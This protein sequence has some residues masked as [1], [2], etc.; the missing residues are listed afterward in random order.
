MEASCPRPMRAPGNLSRAEVGAPGPVDR[1]IYPASPGLSFSSKVNPG[2]SPSASAILQRNAFL[3]RNA[4]AL[5]GHC[6]TFIRNDPTENLV[7]IQRKVM[8]PHSAAAST[9]R[10]P[11]RSLAP[12]I[13]PFTGKYSSPD[14]RQRQFRK[15]K[16]EMS[17]TFTEAP[18]EDPSGQAKIMY[19]VP[20]NGKPAAAWFD[21]G[22]EKYFSERI[23][24]T[25][26]LSASKKM[27][28]PS[29]VPILG[30]RRS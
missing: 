28:R 8:R 2:L 11:S 7:K 13:D 30:F 5:A 6:K 12:S 9:G 21:R 24:S 23:D 10:P 17:S 15:K 22:L 19:M 29:S 26:D 14:P 27:V 18:V 1:W 4:T 25:G 20:K 3:A 16:C